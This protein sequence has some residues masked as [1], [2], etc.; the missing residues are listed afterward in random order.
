MLIILLL[1]Y[2]G[3]L[4]EALKAEDTFATRF[5]GSGNIGQ[6]VEEKL[7]QG[8]RYMMTEKLK[9]KTLLEVMEMEHYETP[10]NLQ[11]LRVP[12]VKDT[13]WNSLSS[14]VQ[15]LHFKA[16]RV[17]KIMIKG[18]TAALKEMAVP[19]KN[20]KHSLACLIAAHNK[21]N[22]LRWELIRPQLNQ[23]L[24]HL[25]RAS[26]KVMSFLFGDDLGK[27][28]KDV[29]ETQK[30]TWQII[31]QKPQHRERRWNPYGTSYGRSRA[32]VNYVNAR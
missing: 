22:M 13:I 12:L 11:E 23:R 2:G 15:G 28:I 5:C 26:V 31:K 8:V 14:K 27:Q 3:N 29:R 9:V 24:T 16:Q 21:L 6:P 18:V 20:E 25:C 1:I 17:Q 30:A 19:K 10:S 4:P 7:A 32:G